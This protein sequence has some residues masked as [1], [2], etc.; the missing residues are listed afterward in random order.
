MASMEFTPAHFGICVSDL[1]RSMRFYCDGLGFEPAER[2]DI[3]SAT[4]PGIENVLEVDAPVSLVSQ[5]L[6]RGAV[7]V[8]LLWYPDRAPTGTPSATR[9]QLGLTHLSFVVDDIDEAAA[10]LVEHGGTVLDHT[11]PGNGMP[12]LFLADPDGTRIELMGG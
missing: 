9:A 5:F 10:A 3:T 4:M 11:S 12:L 6:Q 2:H 8:E 1:E 7:R